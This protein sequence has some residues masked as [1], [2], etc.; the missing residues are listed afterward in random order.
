MHEDKSSA[1]LNSEHLGVTSTN[2][3]SEYE[4][5]VRAVL[6]WYSSTCEQK[7]RTLEEQLKCLELDFYSEVFWS[8]TQNVELR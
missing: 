6:Q 2:E 5:N 7:K 8:K 4:A 3:N 1:I